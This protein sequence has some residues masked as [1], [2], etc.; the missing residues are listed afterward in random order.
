[1]F[2]NLFKKDKP[3]RIDDGIHYTLEDAVHELCYEVKW[4]KR[5][6]KDLRESIHIQTQIILKLQS[7]IAAIHA[8]YRDFLCGDCCHQDVCKIK[9]TVK[10]GFICKDKPCPEM[11]DIE[12]E[13][14]GEEIK[15]L[16]F[17]EDTE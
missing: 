8:H 6:I 10:Y 16:V 12:D 7:D 11:F 1:M 15:P 4:N 3:Y 9:D 2:N 17:K 14:R 13:L 5:H